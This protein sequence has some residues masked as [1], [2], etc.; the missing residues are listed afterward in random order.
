MISVENIMEHLNKNPEKKLVI[1]KQF[2]YFVP[3]WFD[4][5]SKKYDL[6]NLHEED[7]RFLFQSIL[8]SSISQENMNLVNMDI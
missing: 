6:D 4:E 2:K 3:L 8:L 5:K 7:K 1:E